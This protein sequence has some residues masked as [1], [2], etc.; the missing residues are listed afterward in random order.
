MNTYTSNLFIVLEKPYFCLNF[1]YTSHAIFHLFFNTFTEY[2]LQ[3]CVRVK[4]LQLC[5]A[6]CDSMDCSLPGCSALGILQGRILGW[7]AMS[8]S[9]A[10]SR[11]RDQI[12]IS[13]GYCTAGR[14][15][16]AE[17][18]GKPSTILELCNNTKMN[19]TNVLPA[20]SKHTCQG[21]NLRAEYQGSAYTGEKCTQS[22]IRVSDRK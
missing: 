20:H 16:T 14:F 2:L 1:M 22:K 8:S 6:L 7:V 5:L 18:P 9:K 21:L 3:P 11:P 12:H 4:L 10:S 17:P 15:F 13:C 19:K